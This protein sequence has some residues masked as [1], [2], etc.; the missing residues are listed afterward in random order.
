LYVNGSQVATATDSSFS[1]GMVGLSSASYD[2]AG[3]DILFDNFFVYR[4]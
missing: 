3:T 4:P 2:T 1:G